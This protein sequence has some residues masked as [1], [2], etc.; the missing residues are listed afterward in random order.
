MKHVTTLGIDIAKNVFQLHG[1]DRHGDVALKKRLKRD[2]LL[3]YLSQ[4]PP[5]Q[6]GI[7]A[8]G[9]SHHWGRAL[10]K[11]G[12]NIK[13]MS[14]QHVKPYIKANKNDRND[15]SGI[16]EAVSRPS[17]RFVPI[18]TVAQQEIQ[19][20]HR[21]RSQVV[22]QR[23]A[24][25]NSIR[26]LLHEYGVVTKTGR[27]ALYQLLAELTAP[28][29]TVL[30]ERAKPVFIRQYESLKTMDAD[31]SYYDGVIKQQADTDTQCQQLMGIPGI[32]EITATALSASI[33]SVGDFKNGR[34]L[35]AWLGL[36]PKQCS[37]GEK[38]RLFGISKRGDVY[39]RSLL[40]HGARSVVLW[41]AKAAKPDK[42]QRWINQLV[43]RCG[44]NK[45]VVAVAN[46]M[47]R[48]AYGMLSTGKAY[49]PELAHGEFVDMATGEVLY[50]S[51]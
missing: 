17:M 31:I 27:T 11:L 29:S 19:L 30:S 24:Q 16:C 3:N 33:S 5:C 48:I 1:V 28:E 25:M 38:Q 14:P 44:W 8:C 10:Q 43:S 26:G 41:A 42:H 21:S 18:K 23:T 20:I 47:L 40:I 36:V 6:I 50:A 34:A 35:S 45:A 7:E 15:A 46:K 12:H 51:V 49:D 4:L 22:K 13:L 9:G 39:I 32:G 37:S 2:E